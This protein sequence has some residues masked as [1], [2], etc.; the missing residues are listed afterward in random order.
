MDSIEFYVRKKGKEEEEVGSEKSEWEWV[1][2]VFEHE[3]LEHSVRRAESAV[4]GAVM[5]T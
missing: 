1:K 5:L 3:R 4:C 2:L